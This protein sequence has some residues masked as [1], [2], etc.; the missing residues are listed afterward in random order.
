MFVY[1]G[2][3]SESVPPFENPLT[4]A[5]RQRAKERIYM[6]CQT[7]G[8]GGFL[9]VQ[10]FFAHMIASGKGEPV[11]L[12]D[13]LQAVSIVAIGML[14]SHFSRVY[15]GRWGLKEMGWL[16][17]VPRAIGIALLM[18]LIWSIVTA[19]WYYGVMRDPWPNE[20]QPFTLLAISIIN[21]FLIFGGWLSFYFI[22][23]V[24]NRFNISEI[25][26]LRLTTV[27]KDAELRAL[28]SQ[29][30]PHFIFNSLNS[31]RALIDE[32]PQRARSAVTQLANMLRY[33]LQSGLNQTVSFEDE[34]TVVND[35]LALEQVRH[36]ERLRLK[37]DIAPGTLRRVLPPMLLQT[38]VEN[39]VK[40]GISTRASGGEISIAARIENQDLLIE[41]RN[42]GHLSERRSRESTRSTGL[43]LRNALDRL[44]LLC[45]DDAT[46]DLRQTGSDEVTATVMVPQSNAGPTPPRPRIEPTTELKPALSEQ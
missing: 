10:V 6:L 40:Y 13:D 18:S 1:G 31:V 16:R 30:N 2:T 5:K 38:L 39:A 34:L 43:G 12:A 3:V 28:K 21:G 42:P 29:V 46:I 17:L 19:G 27:V 24:F 20:I 37:L 7:I 22:Y 23:H 41:V 4:D 15:V 45:G 25:E 8:W 33:S 32:D 44:Q 26:R 36:E 11:P 14:I 9:V 35:Y